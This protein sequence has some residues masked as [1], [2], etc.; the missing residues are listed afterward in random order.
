MEVLRNAAKKLPPSVKRIL[1]KKFITKKKVKDP[2]LIEFRLKKCK[3][4]DNTPAC[5][6]YD[7]ERDECKSCGCIIEIKV[8]TD[9]EVWKP[10]EL[11]KT[12]CPMGKWLD[13]MWANYYRELDGKELI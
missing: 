12:H 3:G 9:V 13:K 1:A 10:G 6:F 11:R 2:S 4:D 5:E 7:A 8:E